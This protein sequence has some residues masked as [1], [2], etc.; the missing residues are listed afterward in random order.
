[1]GKLKQNTQKQVASKCRYL[2]TGH[3]FDKKQKYY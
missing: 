3:D 2:W 1:M